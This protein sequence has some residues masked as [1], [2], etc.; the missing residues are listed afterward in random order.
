M[1]S[2]SAALVQRENVVL[3]LTENNASV[4]LA[5]LVRKVTALP[6]SPVAIVLLA[7]SVPK[8]EPLALLMPRK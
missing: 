6:E 1:V 5:L 2:A 4:V 8:A 3:V 7:E